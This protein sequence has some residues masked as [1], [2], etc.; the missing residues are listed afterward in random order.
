MNFI[1]SHKYK[2]PKCIV[3]A[4]NI[5]NA[6]QKELTK[7]QQRRGQSCERMAHMSTKDE[8]TN[9]PSSRIFSMQTTSPA[10]GSGPVLNL[11][12]SKTKSIELPKPSCRLGGVQIE[13]EDNNVGWRLV[14]LDSEIRDDESFQMES[15]DVATLQ[16]VNLRLKN[17][18]K[19]MKLKIEILLKSIA[20]QMAF[21]SSNE[22]MLKELRMKAKSLPQ[23]QKTAM[24]GDI[25]HCS[26]QGHFSP[27]VAPV[28]RK[29]RAKKRSQSEPNAS[30]KMS[31]RT[32][33]PMTTTASW[34]SEEN[35]SDI[36]TE[37]ETSNTAIT[38]ATGAA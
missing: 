30:C 13:W 35:W 38:E 2:P 24:S 3:R 32:R 20:E 26:R 36:M 23:V 19:L 17:E 34:N 33:S 10:P 1:A 9:E 31:G 18:R 6:K 27:K 37:N 12:P 22:E 14:P 28:E 21:A 5:L 15:N 16:R 25:A 11:W 4:A 7:R 8:L 29:I